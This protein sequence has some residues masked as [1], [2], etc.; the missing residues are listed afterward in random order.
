MKA[1]VDYIGVSAGAVIVNDDGKYFMAKRSSAARDDHGTWEFPGGTI[2]LFETREA[3]AKR[4]VKRKYGFEIAVEEVLG[5]YDAIDKKAGDHWISTTFRCHYDSG[6]PKIL[7]PTKCDQIGWFTL[8]EIKKLP[9]SRITKL[10]LA[11]L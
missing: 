3:A 4:N 9:L 5:V 1:G 2:E 8:E 10:N 6:Q 11:D 7:D